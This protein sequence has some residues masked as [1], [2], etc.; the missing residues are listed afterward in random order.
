MILLD[1]RVEMLNIVEYEFKLMIRRTESGN[2]GERAF[3][4]NIP[5]D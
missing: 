1:V 4:C 5:A 3:F 2:G